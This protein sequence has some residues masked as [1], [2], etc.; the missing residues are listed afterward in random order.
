M[1]ILLVAVH[2]L[3][4]LFGLLMVIAAIV[5]HLLFYRCPYCGE[6]LG[7]NSGS[8]CPNAAAL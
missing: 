5:I 3:F 6:H 1:L 7:R 4:L 2:F 8:C